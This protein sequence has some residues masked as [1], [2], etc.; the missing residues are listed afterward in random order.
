MSD[1]DGKEIVHIGDASGAPIAT[2]SN[3][4]QVLDS[5]RHPTLFFPRGGRF[6]MQVLDSATGRI[7]LTADIRDGKIVA[8]YDP[9]DLDEAAAVF[10][11]TALAVMNRP[12]AW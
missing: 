8:D 11:E 6:P 1:G 4:F 7:L 2:P 9:A 5:P 3:L 12:Q 10:A